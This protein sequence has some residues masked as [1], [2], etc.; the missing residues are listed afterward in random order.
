MSLI[1]RILI[2]NYKNKSKCINNN[3]NNN[4][5]ESDNICYL[6]FNDIISKEKKFVS[7]VMK[8]NKN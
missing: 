2:E 7:L 8:L 1:K 3:I 5:K 6:P 4:D